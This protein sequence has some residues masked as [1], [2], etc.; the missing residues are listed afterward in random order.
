MRRATGTTPRNVPFASTAYTW[1]NWLSSSAHWRRKASMAFSML[2][3]PEIMMTAV[4]GFFAVISESSSRPLR[5][6]IIMS[7]STN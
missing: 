7:L 5:P 6:G 2:C 3:V 1:Y 4:F